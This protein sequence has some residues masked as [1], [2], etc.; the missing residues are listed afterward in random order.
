MGILWSTIGEI[1]RL[2]ERHERRIATFLREIGD[3]LTDLSPDTRTRNL[4][5][6]RGRIMKALKK[7]P[8]APTD[9]DIDAVLHDCALETIRGKRADV[10]PAKSRGGIALAADNRW[11]LGVCGGLAERFDVPVG[12][13]RAAFV[14]LGLLTW[15]IALSAYA[16]LFFVMYFTG[17]HEESVRV[18]WLRLVTFILGAVAATLAFHFGTK[19]V[20]AGGSWLSIRFLEQDL[21]ALG[22][23]DWLERW[24]GT[25]LRWVLVFVCPIAVLSGLPMANAW[26]KTAKKVLQAFLALY[27]LVLSFGIACA[28]VGI[29]LYVV[30]KFAGFSFLR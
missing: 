14:V 3:Q 4:S 23:W 19:L 18:R 29:I 1:M 16:L 22:R 25:L 15:P 20:F 21:A 10:K 17:T 13:V 9:Q 2:S 11:W 27:A 8:D 5:N 12:G 30:E 28:V 7:L 26:D 24:D 6:L